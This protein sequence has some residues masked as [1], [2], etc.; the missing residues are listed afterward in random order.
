[1]GPWLG[2]AGKLWVMVVVLVKKYRTVLAPHRPGL[3]VC[4]VATG[5]G[6]RDWR[7]PAL[8]RIQPLALRAL[9]LG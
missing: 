9:G 7:N 3:L 2:G 8:S 4:P 6:V 1:M 5:E